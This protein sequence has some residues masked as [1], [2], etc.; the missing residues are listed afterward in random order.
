[1]TDYFIGT[2]NT[3]SEVFE[4][5]PTMSNS[6]FNTNG[7]QSFSKQSFSLIAARDFQITPG[8]QFIPVYN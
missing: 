2:S 4:L 7:I 8:S 1:M 3:Y 6:I 5:A